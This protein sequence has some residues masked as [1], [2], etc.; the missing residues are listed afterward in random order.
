MH[1]LSVVRDDERQTLAMVRDEARILIN[2]GKEI[3]DCALLEGEQLEVISREGLS[4]CDNKLALP[5]MTLAV[6]LSTPEDAED[7][8]V[9]A[10]QQTI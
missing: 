9:A 8:Q 7:R 4:V 2:F 10:R 6:L 1:H 3:F 5:P